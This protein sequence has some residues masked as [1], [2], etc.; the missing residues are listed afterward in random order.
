IGQT[1]RRTRS[2]IRKAMGGNVDV[3]VGYSLGH[4]GA[5]EF[6][7][8]AIDTLVKHMELHHN[9]IVLIVAEY[10]YEIQRAVTLNP[11]LKSRFPFILDFAD[12]DVDQLMDI[13]KQMA[14]EQEYQ[15]TKK[16]EW[17]L[18][19]HLYKQIEEVES[20][21]SNARYVRNIVEYAMRMQAVRLL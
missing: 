2:V 14:G 9:D 4:G 7:K 6:G 12:Y 5:D 21:F 18:R 3:D 11:G 8:D 16:A 1:A 20:N 13:A 15:L 19:T 10:Q 17:K